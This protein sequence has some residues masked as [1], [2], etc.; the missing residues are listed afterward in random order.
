VDGDEGAVD[1]P[2]FP[3]VGRWRAEQVSEVRCEAVDDAVHCGVGDVEQR[4]D[5]PR[6]QVGSVGEHERKD[7]VGEGQGPRAS[8]A[9]VRT[10]VP[11][12]LDE[13]AELAAGQPGPGP[14]VNC[15][16]VGEP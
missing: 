3:P 1:D 14:E 11:Q 2:W 4:R 15:R 8:A 10:P 6:G 5:L 13:P 12:L 9:G 16:A 7:P